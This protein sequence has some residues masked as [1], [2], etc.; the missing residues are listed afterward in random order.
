MNF[1]I[2][3]YTYVHYLGVW[4]DW[5]RRR[6]IFAHV[7]KKFTDI[8]ICLSA[9]LFDNFIFFFF[10]PQFYFFVVQKTFGV[11]KEEKFMWIW[12][13]SQHTKTLSSTIMEDLLNKE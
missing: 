6:Y 5:W 2:I 10:V 7:I 12:V 3:A 1:E 4:G 11:K 13:P 9:P 8:C